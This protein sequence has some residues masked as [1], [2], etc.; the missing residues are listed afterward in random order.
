VRQRHI[1][2]ESVK[3]NERD[4][5]ENLGTEGRMVLKQ[6]LKTMGLLLRSRSSSLCVGS[7]GGM[8][9]AGF[10]PTISVDERPQTYALDRA[11]TGTGRKIDSR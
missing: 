10:E 8:P 7:N 5:L 11:V 6:V 1:A 3:L 9:P 4:N 2:F